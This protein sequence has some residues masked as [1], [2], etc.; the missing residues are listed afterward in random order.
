MFSTGEPQGRTGGASLGRRFQLVWTS[1]TVSSLGDGMRFVALPLLAARVSGDPRDL[2]LVAAAEQLPWLL[3][4]LPAGALAD[5]VDRRRLLVTVDAGRTVLAAAFAVAVALGAAGVPLLAAVGFLLG[6]GQTLYNAG[7]AGVVPSLVEPA[8]RPRA[9]GRLQAGVMACDSLVGSSLGTALFAVAA[10]LP[11]ASD[12][13][14]FALAALLM[15]LVPGGLPRREER[16]S[17]GRGGLRGLLAETGE[18]VR[19]LARHRLLRTLCLSAATG[20][21]VMAGVTAELVLYTRRVLHLGPVGY[22]LMVGAFAVGGVAGSL[23]APWL[24]RRLGSVR[25][26]VLTLA[27]SG[28]ALGAAGLGTDWRW[29]GPAGSCYGA[30]TLAWG[31]TSVSIRQDLVPEVLLGRISMAYQMVANGGMAVG[32]ALAG[33][34]AHAWGLRAPMLAGAV[35]LLVATPLLARVARAEVPGQ[36]ATSSRRLAAAPA[37]AEPRTSPRTSGTASTSSESTVITAAQLHSAPSS[38]RP[39]AS[40]AAAAVPTGASATDPNQS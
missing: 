22:G 40:G 27:G 13:V 12:A 31:I 24:V 14:S 15:L 17:Q 6:C 10:V 39:P 16:G 36:A 28:L 18:G 20:N 9:N 8:D 19:R 37:G 23:G 5:R 30:L 29:V 26:L 33:L 35:V 2:A 32:A 34:V 11:F 21:V 1:V 25:T 4:S 7:W 38:P 3:L